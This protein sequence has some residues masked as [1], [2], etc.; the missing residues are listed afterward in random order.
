MDFTFRIAAKILNYDQKVLP[1]K[2]TIQPEM[3]NYKIIR[4]LQRGQHYPVTFT[5]HNLRTKEQ[6]IEKVGTRFLFAPSELEALLTDR[7]FLAKYGLTPE[8]C[9]AIFFPDTYEIYFDITAEDFF[10]KFYGFYTNFWDEKRKK[11]A[12]EIGISPTDISTIA[13][14]VE[15][16][17]LRGGEKAMIAGVYINRINRSWKL[18]ADPTLKFAHHNFAI[19]RVTNEMKEIDSPYNTYKY[20]GIPPGPIR[21]PEK[22]TL[23]SVLHYTRHNYMFMCAKDDFSGRHNFARTLEEHNY[24]A[25]KYR[26]ALDRKRIYK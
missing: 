12:E 11:L 8:N 6:F 4:Y 13:S 25:Y 16:E 18:E 1:G 20:T 19:R 23:D 21:I 7:S 15:E 2:Y 14:I 3:G 9:L 26:K 5:F 17:N 22:S 24:N 10:H